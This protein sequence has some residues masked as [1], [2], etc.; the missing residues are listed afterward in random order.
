MP[1]KI[2]QFET[3]TSSCPYHMQFLSDDVIRNAD[4]SDRSRAMQIE[5]LLMLLLLL[6]F[7]VYICLQHGHH[8]GRDAGWS[9]CPVENHRHLCLLLR[10][11][12]KQ[13]YLVLCT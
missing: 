9:Q 5:M 8:F 6:L 1:T 3:W 2:H 13:D 11:D 4:W 7:T 10:H 12:S